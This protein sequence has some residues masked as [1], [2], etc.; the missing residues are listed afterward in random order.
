MTEKY[1][2]GFLTKSPIQPTVEAAPGIWKLDEA[3]YA[4]KNNSWPQPIV[5]EPPI[6]SIDLTRTTEVDPRL[7]FVRNS[8]ATYYDSQGVLSTAAPAEMRMD[9]DPATGELLGVLIEEARTN[10]LQRSEELD[11]A[12]WTKS[13]IE[14]TPN[15][16]VSPDG[17]TTVDSISETEVESVHGIVRSGINLDM[18]TNNYVFSV[19]VKTDN[20]KNVLLKID[21]GNGNDLSVLFAMDSG[22]PMLE[23]INGSST[24]RSILFNELPN[25]WHRISMTGKTGVNGSH[26]VSLLLANEDSTVY[27]GS[28]SESYYVWGLQLEQGD[29]PTSYIKTTG[30]TAQR[31]ADILTVL[32]AAFLNFYNENEGTVFFEGTAVQNAGN[33]ATTVGASLYLTAE[34]NLRVAFK[35]QAD[36]NRIEL[37]GRL[38]SDSIIR[39]FASFPEYLNIVEAI[40]FK[41]ALGLKKTEYPKIS[42]NGSAVREGSTGNPGIFLSGGIPIVFLGNF[43]GAVSSSETVQNGHVKRFSYWNK[44]LSDRHLKYISSTSYNL[45]TIFR[46]DFDLVSSLDYRISFSRNSAGT[47]FNSTGSLTVATNDEPRFDHDP[48]TNSKIGLLIE[49]PRTNLANFSEE[50]DNAYWTKSNITVVADSTAAPDTNSTADSIIETASTGEH[51]FYVDINSIDMTSAVYSFSVFVKANGRSKVSLELSDNSTNKVTAT[52]DITAKTISHTASGSATSASSKI[53]ELSNGWFRVACSG[54]TGISGTHRFAVKILDDSGS[55]TYSGDA[56]KGLYVWGAQIEEGRRSSS[57]IP[58][59]DST[60]TR[61][62]DI[63][64]INGINFSTWFNQSEGT[65]FWQG[66]TEGHGNG[67]ATGFEINDNTSSERYQVSIAESSDATAS[68][69]KVTD[70]GTDVAV[71]D[72]PDPRQAVSSVVTY[73]QIFSYK[74]NDIFFLNKSNS[75]PTTSSIDTT[76]TLPSVSQISLGSSYVSDAGSGFLNGHISKF[77]YWNTKLPEWRSRDI[78]R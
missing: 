58:T 51:G 54:L 68:R 3:I 48:L 52:A 70:G 26:E 14:L 76:A 59:Y 7:V 9:H 5:I 37:V 50:V 4:I 60:V 47:Y 24:L 56:S 49:E 62:G 38:E 23:N 35:G 39:T 17:T 64:L 63:V 72:S 22:F 15:S 6:F 45:D 57:Y 19:F 11:N 8:N 53:T 41:T 34:N 44:R 12:Y 75:M 20:V 67:S 25:G 46:L 1:L 29:F 43:S 18:V 13:N 40:P 66:R 33:V 69:A 32:D 78:L 30:S 55:S 65:V 74:L 71:L 42:I 73:S 10:I 61:E 27:L 36:T 16:A 31:V 2:G 28:S 77:Y 21:G